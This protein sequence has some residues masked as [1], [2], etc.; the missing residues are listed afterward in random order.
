KPISS[1][2]Y[3]VLCPINNQ[4]ATIIEI[5]VN[6]ACT[7]YNKGDRNI[8]ENS[9]GSVIPVKKAV[10]AILTKNPPTAALRCF[11]AATY[12]ARQTPGKPNI[13]IGNNPA[14]K[15]PTL[16]SPCRKRF[17]SPFTT[18]P[19]A[20]VNVPKSNQIRKLIT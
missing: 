7:T 15:N 18:L 6:T 17:I 10:K 20:S 3:K 9:I 12:I 1:P 11:L 14:I 2:V 8:N 4:N 16:G 13:I 5:P 19:A